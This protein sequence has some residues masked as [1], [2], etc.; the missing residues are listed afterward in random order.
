MLGPVGNAIG[1]AVSTLFGW[2]I[3]AVKP[4]VGRV[5]IALGLSMITIK[6]S[7]VAFT[8]F[9][10]KLEQSI[11]GLALDVAQIA[12]LFGLFDGLG[13]NMGSAAFIVSYFMAAKFFSF[14]GYTGDGK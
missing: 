2:L 14:F 8:Q 4:I 1:G 6:G 11:D 7:D 12:G 5:L 10:Q 9:Q 13:I 3:N